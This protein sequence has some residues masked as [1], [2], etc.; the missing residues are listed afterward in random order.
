MNLTEFRKLSAALYTTDENDLVKMAGP[1]SGLKRLLR[2]FLNKVFSEEAKGFQENNSELKD[3]LRDLYGS[4]KDL[5]NSIDDYDLDTYK[6]VLNDVRHRTSKLNDLLSKIRSDVSKVE[7]EAKD[8]I[9]DRY[10]LKE[11]TDSPKQESTE[12]VHEKQSKPHASTE[13][14][15]EPVISSETEK[16]ISDL[17]PQ[18]EHTVPADEQVAT[19]AP[20]VRE[21]KPVDLAN[22]PRS[23]PASVLDEAYQFYFSESEV[24]KLQKRI[25]D[26]ITGDAS[27]LGYDV[28]VAIAGSTID[29][30][31]RSVNK[32][33][34]HIFA[35]EVAFT[36]NGSYLAKPTR[37]FA[38]IHLDTRDGRV[39][40]LNVRPTEPVKSPVKK[41]WLT[42]NVNRSL[43]K[44]GR[45]LGPNFW[46]KFNSMAQRLGMRPEI[47]LPIMYIESAGFNPQVSTKGGAAGLIQFLPST[48]KGVGYNDGIEG[49]SKLSGEEQLDYIEKFIGGMMS[50]NGGRPYKDSASYYVSN[51]W[52][53]ALRYRSYYEKYKG[54]AGWWPEGSFRDI[55]AGDPDAVIVEANP[56]FRKSPNFSIAQEA[57]AYKANPFLDP[58]KDG[59]I[60]LGD[61][62]QRIEEVKKLSG[63]Q[64]LERDLQGASNYTATPPEVTTPMVSAPRTSPEESGIIRVLLDNLN[65]PEVP[66]TGNFLQSITD[67]L[68]SSGSEKTDMIEVFGKNKHVNGEFMRAASLVLSR[69]YGL[70]PDVYASGSHFQI[71]YPS[72]EVSPDSIRLMCSEIAQELRQYVNNESSFRFYVR[73]DA[74]SSLPPLPIERAQRLTRIFKIKNLK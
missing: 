62:Q 65:M 48:L 12:T 33:M 26:V 23:F 71:V 2:R 61:L 72:N 21:E 19:P 53:D 36:L 44:N 54:Q 68:E 14:Y 15:A 56:Q 59:K 39:H 43:R 13:D 51:F 11:T 28:I 40:V 18:P 41:S 67:A 27:A 31:T 52:P 70:I 4:F 37:L 35:G 24:V 73:K 22:L 17:A 9:K 57:G 74:Q 6:R 30:W 66:A 45:N 1:I 64:Q 58:N 60:T 32:K 5:E 10:Y 20:A 42:P 34:P 47:L 25:E 46:T 3:V 8:E 29:N 63:Y 7:N 50:F 49:F 69:D 16:L 55:Q 38:R